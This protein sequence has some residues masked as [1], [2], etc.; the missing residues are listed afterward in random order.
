MIKRQSSRTNDNATVSTIYNV[1][2]A[3]CKDNNHGYSKTMSE[4][5]NDLSVH[6]GIPHQELV[7]HK[8]AGNYYKDY[9]LS[10]ETKQTYVR[11]YGY[12]A[13]EIET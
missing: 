4:F 5:R 12:D 9:T 7:V 13:L 3:W 6:L 10:Y 8:K 2:R 1:Y 11:E